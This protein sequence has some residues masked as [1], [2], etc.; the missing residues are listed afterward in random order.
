MTN[1]ITGVATVLLAGA[2]AW[3]AWLAYKAN[4]PIVE[5]VLRPANAER[6]RV[7]LIVRNVGRSPAFDVTITCMPPEARSQITIWPGWE[8]ERL[9]G[10][11]QGLLPG[12]PIPTLASGESLHS[13]I[14]N[15]LRGLAEVTFHVEYKKRPHGRKTHRRDFIYSPAQLYK[16]G[17]SGA[18]ADTGP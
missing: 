3:Y 12:G 16:E 11:S 7:S 17:V 1:W 6:P 18:S 13:E 2:T 5:V 14:A 15:S 4:D 9:P 8:L 10:F